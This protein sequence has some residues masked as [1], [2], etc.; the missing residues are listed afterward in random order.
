MSPKGVEHYRYGYKDEFEFCASCIH[1][2]RRKALS[3][4][5]Y[6]DRPGCGT[7]TE[8]VH[9]SMSPKGVEHVDWEPMAFGNAECIH[10]CRRKALSTNRRRSRGYSGRCAFI[11][12]AERR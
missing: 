2:C 9:S 6:D 12:V 11:N 7:S 3:T 4:A 1:Q 8:R 5:E 10:Q